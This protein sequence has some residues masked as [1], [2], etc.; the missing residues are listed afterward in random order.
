[1][2]WSNESKTKNGAKPS[3]VENIMLPNIGEFCNVLS[4]VNVAANVISVKIA[5][6]KYFIFHGFRVTKS[7]RNC[8]II[9]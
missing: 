3:A 8:Y 9:N 2:E 4:R 5:N 6:F 7:F 1:M